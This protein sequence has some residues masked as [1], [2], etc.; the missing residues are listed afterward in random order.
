MTA[1]GSTEG[2]PMHKLP[3]LSALNWV[4][5]ALIPAG[6]DWR[7][8]PEQV[9]LTE[10][11]ARQN[12][13][14]GVSDWGAP[15]HGVLGHHEVRSTWGSVADPRVGC[16]RREGGHGVK[17]WT[18]ASTAVIGHPIIDNFP[19]QVADVRLAPIKARHDGT[20]GVQGWAQP[21]HTVTGQHGRRGWDSAADPRVPEISGPAI[22]LTNKRKTYL[23][24]RAAD[25]T[26]HRPLTT[27]ELAAL[28]GFPVRMADGSWLVLG[29]S[30]AEQREHIGNAVPPPAAEAIAAQCRATLLAAAA[31]GFTLDNGAIWVRREDVLAA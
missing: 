14:F 18:D 8:L 21:S 10:R 20:N 24:I 12:G 23:V 16:K 4:R 2:G 30:K 3:E 22:D 28:Q 31:G 11:P 1:A 5:L 29:G 15:S 7:A 19:A 17:A 26:W 6:K 13:G 25:G 27:L 9:L